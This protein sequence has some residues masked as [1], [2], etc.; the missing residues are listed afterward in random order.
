MY[1]WNELSLVEQY[2]IEY[3]DMYKS[4][5]GCRPRFDTSSWDEAR[6]EAELDD[7]SEAFQF[8]QQR[9]RREQEA[10]WE[11][12]LNQVNSVMRLVHNCTVRR[13]VEFIAEG[14]GISKKELKWYGWES[15]EYRLGIKFDTIK[16]WLKSQEN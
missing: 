4:T 16:K 14:E 13:A 8:E 12:F 15:L 7:L 2:A 1:N 5:Y 11:D 6:W 10:A 3:S 9:E